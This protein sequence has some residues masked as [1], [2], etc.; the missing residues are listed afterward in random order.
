MEGMKGGGGR[1]ETEWKDWEG[2]KGGME[3][4]EEL[5]AR[6]AHDQHGTLDHPCASPGCPFRVPLDNPGT[7]IGRPRKRRRE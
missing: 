1:E 3:G 6:S 7:S 4:M 5:D 2:R